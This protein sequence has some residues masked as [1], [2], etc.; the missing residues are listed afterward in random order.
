VRDRDVV[1]LEQR[2]EN[3]LSLAYQKEPYKV[4]V[5]YGDQVVLTSPQA[6]QCRRNLQRV[7]AFKVSDKEE[8]TVSQ[9]R[10][11][12]A[13]EIPVDPAPVSPATP[14][15]V[16]TPF[17]KPGKTTAVS[18]RSTIPMHWTHPPEEPP[19]MRR[20][21]RVIRLKYPEKLIDSTITKFHASQD[22]T[23]NCIVPTDNPVRITLPFKA[24]KSADIVRDGST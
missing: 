4:L 24:Q 8:Q 11:G 18:C 14:A 1:L 10:H 12:F 16:S 6:V 23:Q 2:R 13:T 22:Q 17:R 19:P 5:R 9:Q 15:I 21:G 7:K 20:S 3:K